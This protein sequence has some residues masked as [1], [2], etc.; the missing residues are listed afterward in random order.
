LFV[1]AIDRAFRQITGM[2]GNYSPP[3]GII[4]MLKEV[5]ATL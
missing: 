5:V 3:T 2:N 4:S 1:I